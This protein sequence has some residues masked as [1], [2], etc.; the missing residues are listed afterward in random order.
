MH[1]ESHV[2]QGDLMYVSRH[3]AL[4]KHFDLTIAFV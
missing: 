4:P 3:N 1:G 2:F